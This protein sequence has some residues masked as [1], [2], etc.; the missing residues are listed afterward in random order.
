MNSGEAFVASVVVAVDVDADRVPS[1]VERPAPR[2]SSHP[3]TS[4]SQ[5]PD[6]QHETGPTPRAIVRGGN[7]SYM[8]V[9]L[10]SMTRRQV[11]AGL[12]SGAVLVA[13]PTAAR[14]AKLFGAITG[15]VTLDE[16]MALSEALTDD[17]FNLRDEVGA[18]YQAAL[19]PAALSRLVQAT[20]RTANPPRTFN[21]ILRSGALDDPTNAA[22]AQQILTYWYSGLVND[23]TADY[24]EALAWESLG[25]AV[26]SSTKIGF[27][28]WAEKP[29]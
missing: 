22:T 21:D 6:R 15:P 13:W 19:D 12:A 18:Q 16:F 10:R 9:G 27:P 1:L 7:V 17:E 8:A 29:S 5:R 28:K 2:A 23:K 25:F 14:G 26:P 3:K 11:V 4:Q 24:L 20:V